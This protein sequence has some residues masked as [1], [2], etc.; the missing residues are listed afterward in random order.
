MAWVQYIL[1]SACFLSALISATTT[2]WIGISDS[3]DEG[4]FRYQS[5][6]EPVPFAHY[7]DV[8]FHN[9]MDPWLSKEPNNGNGNEDCVVMDVHDGK[10]NDVPCEKKTFSICEWTWMVFCCRNC[11]DLLWEKIVLV[12]RG[13]RPRICKNFEVTRTI[14]SNR[15]RSKQLMQNWE[16]F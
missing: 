12:I 11:Y 10:W 16:Y 13:W 8:Q 9:G 15:E 5:N 7:S 2:W 3:I 1:G 6:G 4:T 14:Y